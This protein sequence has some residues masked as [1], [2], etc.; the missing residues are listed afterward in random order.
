MAGPGDERRPPTLGSA[1]FDELLREVLGRVNGVLDERERW[2]LLLDA[3]GSMAADL[4]LDELLRRI[5]EIARDLAGA[6]YAALGVLG[7]GAGRA[8]AA[9]H[10]PRH[11]SRPGAG[12]RRPAGRAR[13]ARADHR[14]ARAAAAARHRRAPRV[15]RLPAEP[16][17]D[18]V[19]PRGAGAD[20]GQGVRQ[21]LPDRE[22]RRG[23]LHRPGRADRHRAR[24]RR[25]RGHRERPAPRGGGAAR[26]LA[27]GDGGDH[28]P[29]RRSRPA[30][31][32]ALQ[33]VADRAR[34]VAGADIA[35]VVA[36]D[37]GGPA[38]RS[39]WSPGRRWT[40]RRWPGCPSS[41]S[42][43]SSVVRTGIPVSVEDIAS[44]P[45]AVDV[46]GQLGWPPTRAGDHRAAAQR[47]RRG[48][49]SWR[50]GGCRTGC[51]SSTRSTPTC[52]PGS[53]SRPR[54]RSRWPGP[55]TT[56][57]GSR[58]SRTGTGSAATCTTW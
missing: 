9:V 26:A 31:P 23:R 2:E 13:A 30:G 44:H 48:R 18:A 51:R 36:G 57:S 28:R 33:I 20:P 6:Q 46:A 43:A 10:H 22:G 3:V 47:P 21:P 16:P 17:A 42:I 19:V 29:A 14:P 27:G 11:D 15:V 56:S 7:D 32:D 41:D 55:A 12:D 49:A 5:V 52:P 50:W 58:S 37:D 34:E 24:G 39:G 38:L 54:W 8:A 1:E 45:H 53:P 25:R 35:W 40:P 4:S